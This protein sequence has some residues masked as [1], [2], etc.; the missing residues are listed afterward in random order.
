MGGPLRAARPF[1]LDLTL[2]SSA[3]SATVGGRCRDRRSG[4]PDAPPRRRA[5]ACSCCRSERATAIDAHHRQLPTSC[6]ASSSKSL[7]ARSAKPPSKRAEEAVCLIAQRGRGI[8]PVR[9]RPFA[10]SRSCRPGLVARQ[11]GRPVGG[12]AGPADN[13]RHLGRGQGGGQVVL[14]A[15]Q[16][17]GDAGRPAR[18]D[19]RRLRA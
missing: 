3:R 6:S 13:R 14:S 18:L 16:L 19:G 2:R 12:G 7:R 11:D 9:R 17:P 1:S 5:A 8:V 4:L 15:G 10:T